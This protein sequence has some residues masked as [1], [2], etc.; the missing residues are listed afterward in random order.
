[1][2]RCEEHMAQSIEN[3]PLIWRW[4]GSDTHHVFSAS[5]LQQLVPLDADEIRAL[6]AR[7]THSLQGSKLRRDTFY[8]MKQWSAEGPCSSDLAALQ[9]PAETHISLLWNPT[10]ALSTVWGLFEPHWDAFCYAMSDDVLITPDDDSWL[11]FYEHEEVFHFGRRR[12]GASS[13]P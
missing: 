7:L 13:H 2:K 9:I 1:M 11:L 5:M 4:T 8:A 3:F 12:A 6:E 10:T